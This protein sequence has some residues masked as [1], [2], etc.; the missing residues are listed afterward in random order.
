[1]TAPVQ[2]FIDI[3]DG[4]QREIFFSIAAAGRLRKQY[5]S[6]ANAMAEE[7]AETLPSIV[8]E[9]LVDKDGLTVEK[10]SELISV[11]RAREIQETIQA[12]LAGVTLDEHRKR[13]S[14]LTRKHIGFLEAELNAR[15]IL[16]VRAD[17][18]DSDYLSYL[19]RKLDLI[20]EVAVKN[21]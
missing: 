2:H 6:F 9:G 5:G 12:A 16:L 7:A 18:D 19:S 15:K 21:D 3:G 20:G 14:D 1:M 8:F 11:G 4:K 10:I 17:R 13:L